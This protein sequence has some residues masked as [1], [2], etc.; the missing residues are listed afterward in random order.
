MDL[1]R[2]H[3]GPARPA[4]HWGEAVAADVAR[5][6]A[7]WRG[8][9]EAAGGSGDFLFGDF[10]AADAAYAPVVLRFLSYGVALDPVCAAY[11]DAVVAWPALAV[12]I[13]DADAE[14]WMITF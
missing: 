14:P 9:R 5:I 10:T 13:A 7:L 1:R 6:C 8:C 4:D 12:W 3:T 2:R 11:R